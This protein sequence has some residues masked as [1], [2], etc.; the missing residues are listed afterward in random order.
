MEQEWRVNQVPS[1][2]AT[3]TP[4]FNL[5][6]FVQIQLGVGALHVC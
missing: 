5:A 4:S 1:P 3:L 2:T 6:A